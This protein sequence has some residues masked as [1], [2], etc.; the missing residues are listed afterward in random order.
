[1]GALPVESLAHRGE[2]IGQ[3]EDVTGDEQVGVLG[4]DGVPVDALRRDGDF[5]H[6]IH[7]RQRHAFG[8]EAAERNAADHPVFVGD[9]LLVEK[10]SELLGL[11][12]G[13]N[14]RRQP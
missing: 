12:I 5:G 6:Q 4:P 13:G 8:R 7:A 10:A 11:V 9:V 2:G 14:G 3:R 1:V